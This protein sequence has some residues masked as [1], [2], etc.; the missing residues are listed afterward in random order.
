MSIFSLTMHAASEG[1][2]LVLAWGD[3]TRHEML[4]DLGRRRDFKRLKPLLAGKTFELVVISHI[5]ADHIEGFVP[6]FEA[7]PPFSTRAIWYNGRKQLADAQNRMKP[8]QREV[9]GAVQAEKVTE[10]ITSVHWPW[11]E[12]FASRIVSIDSPEAAAP[13]PLPG[14]LTLTLLSPSDAALTRLIPKWDKELEEHRLRQGDMEE[15][16]SKARRRRETFGA[17]D[18]EALAREPHAE[19]A[20]EANGA[21]IAFLA[22]YRGKCVLLAADAHPDELLK[23]LKRQERDAANPQELACFKLSHHGSKKNTVARLLRAVTCR[24]FAISTDGTHHH[25]PDREAMA[26]I[27]VNDKAGEKE[28]IFNS[29][30]AEAALWAMPDAQ[31]TWNYTCRY[32]EAG[33]AFVVIDLL[34]G[35][36][37]EH[38]T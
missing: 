27:L 32:P 19:D 18:I 7:T 9:F 22:E 33:E 36:S 37:G 14:G 15:A 12:G 21:S 20:S 5:D 11:N 1:D 6:L 34:D 8:P 35:T 17:F 24:R 30:H 26:R 13:I 16:G 2:A 38:T 10:G 25:H 28:L 4:I 31:E 29:R 23:G 3:E